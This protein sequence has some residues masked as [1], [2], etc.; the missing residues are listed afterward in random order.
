MLHFAD[1]VAASIEGGIERIAPIRYRRINE[2]V[3]DEQRD[4]G[5]GEFDQRPLA[6]FE[7]LI[8]RLQLRDRRMYRVGDLLA[9]RR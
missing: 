5:A 7:L 9:I 8:A 3:R 1:F 2:G 4:H 6:R